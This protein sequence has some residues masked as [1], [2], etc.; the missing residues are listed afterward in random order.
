MKRYPLP[1]EYLLNLNMDIILTI[2]SFLLRDNFLAFTNFFQVF[3]MYKNDDE[4]FNLLHHLDWTNMHVH[5]LSWNQVVS[6]RFSRFLETSTEMMVIHAIAYNACNN[7]ILNNQ[8]N[9]N[10]S[11]LQILA[12]HDHLSFL[13]LHIFRPFFDNNVFQVSAKAVHFR[14]KNNQIFNGQLQSFTEAFNG[15]LR[16]CTGGWDARQVMKPS[17]PMCQSYKTQPADHFSP[18]SW[19]AHI[20]RDNRLHCWIPSELVNALMDKFVEGCHYVISNF[21]VEP[22]NQ[23]DRCFEAELHIVLHSNTAITD[24]PRSYS[25]IPKDIFCL[26]NLKTM[27]E[28]AQT[29]DYLIDL[30]GIVEDL[31]PMEP[32]NGPALKNI[33]T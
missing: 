11:L 20:D 16:L 9:Q 18:Y 21:S 4:V 29:H 19:P 15:R 17:F 6:S 14:F 3:V 1:E 24:M 27:I 12:H 25:Q 26:K 30:V 22:F 13:A 23:K 5:K 31:K 2:C 8:V 32:V 28:S 33:S 7:L 10:M